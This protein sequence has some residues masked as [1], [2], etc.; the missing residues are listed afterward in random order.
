M[1]TWHFYDLASGVFSGQAFSGPWDSLEANLPPGHGAM[2]NVVDWRSQRVDVSSLTVVDW[3]PPAPPADS[4]R[5]WDW[6]PSIRRWVAVDTVAAVSARVRAER[7]R[8][9]AAT[10]W[11][12]TASAPD[13]LGS[14]VYAAWQV[15]RQA[16]RDVTTQPG[17]PADVIWPAKPAG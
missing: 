5:S 15:Y 17:F 3:Q 11:T 8:L 14:E 4:M 16:L 6:E 2:A 1:N 12:D 10:D 7:D 13:R 9:L